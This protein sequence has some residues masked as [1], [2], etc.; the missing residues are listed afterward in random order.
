MAR[1]F[2][3]T[4]LLA[5]VGLAGCSGEVTFEKNALDEAES[6]HELNGLGI[7]VPDGYSFR[8]MIKMPPPGSGGAS[9]D[10][11]FESSPPPEPVEVDSAPVPMTPTTCQELRKSELP[12]GLACSLL[13]DLRHGAVLLTD[14]ADN[15]SVIS[16]QLPSGKSRIYVSVSGH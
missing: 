5:L 1:Y 15:L 10:G 9:Y 4:I 14:S 2:L 3:G 12:D 8:S 13:S 16:G 6:Q 7:T 11:V